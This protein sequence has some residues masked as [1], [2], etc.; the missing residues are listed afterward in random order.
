MLKMKYI[1]EKEIHQ[2]EVKN[3]SSNIVQLLGDFPVLT[4]GFDLFKLNGKYLGNY[5]AYTTVYR[6]IDGGVQF[7]NDGSEYVKPKA[8]ISFHTNGGGTLDGETAQEV[9][10]YEDLAIP[11][12]IANKN[13]E[14]AQWN[15][16]IPTSGDV[17]N[18]KV[19]TA[20][21]QYI[22]TLSEIQ[23]AK[24][25]EM[26][27]I[28]Q[29]TIAS[30]VDV[31]LSDGETYHFALTT[32][33]QLSIMGSVASGETSIKG[34]PWHIADESVHCRYYSDEDMALISK[35]AYSCVLFH[36]TYFRDLRIYIRG[37][38]TKEEVEAVSYGMMIPE[39]Y[40][41]EVLQDMYALMGVN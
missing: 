4:K 36:V 33:D 3:I 26:N 8:T 21:F 14:F 6:E 10:R 13:Y 17:E 37:L 29:Q 12:P 1:G 7:S 25:A 19:F 16:E 34:T 38:Q 28:Q 15:P 31:A 11:T 5:S 30:G 9:Y 35:A 27:A 23:E 2:V 24:V 40:R 18:N 39:E 41:S 20:S 22:P 32:N